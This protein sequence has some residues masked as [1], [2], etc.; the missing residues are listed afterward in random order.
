MISEYAESL[1]GQLGFDRSLSQRVR[2]E[3]EDH[4]RDAVAAD[5]SGDALAAERRAIA[6]FGDPRVI[7]AQFA[8]ASLADRTRRIGAT[9]ILV[10]AGVFFAMTTRVTWYD[11]TQWALCEDL[12]ALSE[13]VGLIDRSA[14]WL[15]VIGG[16]AGWAY[17]SS[18]YVPTALDPSY[19]KQLQRFLLLCAIATG[20]LIAAVI[21]D[22]VLTALRL[23]GWE[24]SVDFL[25]PIFSMAV[26]IVCA[27]VLVFHIRGAMRR[28]AA[29]SALLGAVPSD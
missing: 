12:I 27:G 18:H 15:A 16:T 29:T 2:Q 9:V 11:L 10:V 17:I 26:E 13:T 23:S 24:F 1:A 3:V 25:I 4:L 6:N 5:R 14:F 28:M 8:V 22:G 20:G 7:A 21:C 19:R